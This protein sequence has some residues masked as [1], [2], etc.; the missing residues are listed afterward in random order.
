M[1]RFV[2]VKKLELDSKRIRIDPKH[3]DSSFIKSYVITTGN[4]TESKGL[5][6]LESLIDYCPN[7]KVNVMFDV[8]IFSLILCS[9]R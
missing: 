2:H 5:L 7:L 4:Y 6:H 3:V 1:F 9:S 8:H